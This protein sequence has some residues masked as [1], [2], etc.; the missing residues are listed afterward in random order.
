MLKIV[1]SADLNS[2]FLMLLGKKY[3]TWPFAVNCEKHGLVKG[4]I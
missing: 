4:E 2:Q 1:C 3:G